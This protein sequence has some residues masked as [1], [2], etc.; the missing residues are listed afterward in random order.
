MNYIESL[1]LGW[2]DVQDE[3]F[4]RITSSCFD[5]SFCYGASVLLASYDADEQFAPSQARIDQQQRPNPERLFIYDTPR[6]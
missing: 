4:F 5:P 1:Q 3:R 6:S 2:D